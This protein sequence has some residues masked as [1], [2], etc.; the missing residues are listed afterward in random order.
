MN[1]E[2]SFEDACQAVS[3]KLKGL[4]GRDCLEKRTLLAIIQDRHEDAAK[5]LNIVERRNTLNLYS[6]EGGKAFP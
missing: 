1:Y 6:V 5:L 4:E 2:L 3:K